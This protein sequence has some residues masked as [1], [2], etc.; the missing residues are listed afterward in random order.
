MAA[1]RNLRGQVV[2][3]R[4]AKEQRYAPKEHGKPRRKVGYLPSPHRRECVEQLTTFLL[5][6]M[7]AP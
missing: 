5:G 3:V 6:E 2:H 1:S 4:E 7:D